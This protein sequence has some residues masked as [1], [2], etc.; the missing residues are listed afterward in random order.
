MILSFLRHI[1]GFLSKTVRLKDGLIMYETRNLDLSV[2]RPNVSF[3]W[4]AKNILAKYTGVVDGTH[5]MQIFVLM[6]KINKHG[7][8]DLHLVHKQQHFAKKMLVSL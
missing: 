8:W 4:L 3:T 2:Y 6:C 7:L 1:V 5:V